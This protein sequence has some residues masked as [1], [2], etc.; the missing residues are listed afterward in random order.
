[1]TKLERLFQPFEYIFQPCTIAGA[2]SI[3]HIQT[4]LL[5]IYDKE[6]NPFGVERI[7]KFIFFIYQLTSVQ[8]QVLH[9]LLPSLFVLIHRY[10]YNNYI[11]VFKPF[12]ESLG[13][14]WTKCP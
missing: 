2:R 6:R 12:F 7:V 4:A 5:I 9:F 14:G 11:G 1:M 8:T 10:R 13:K 3:V